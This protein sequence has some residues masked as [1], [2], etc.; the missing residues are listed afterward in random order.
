MVQVWQLESTNINNT[1]TNNNHPPSFENVGAIRTVMTSYSCLLLI[2]LCWPVLCV[3]VYDNLSHF[4]PQPWTKLY[5]LSLIDGFGIKARA[6]DSLFLATILPGQQLSCLFAFMPSFL[7]SSQKYINTHAVWDKFSNNY[8]ESYIISIVIHISFLWPQPP[9]SCLAPVYVG[10]WWWCWEGPEGV[11]GVQFFSPQST[12]SSKAVV[13]IVGIVNS[14]YPKIRRSLLFL[15]PNT[16]N[17]ILFY[18]YNF[19][20]TVCHI[21]HFFSGQFWPHF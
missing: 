21:I 14:K 17:F 13:V 5:C 4:T 18:R 10:G 16:H 12:N 3:F 11:V 2:L 19:T 8:W 1:A 20:T 15:T 9:V 7:Q 6:L